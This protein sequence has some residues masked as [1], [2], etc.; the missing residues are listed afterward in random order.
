MAISNINQLLI[1]NID[2]LAAARPL[3]VN[4]ADDGFINAYLTQYPQACMDSYH[5]NYAEYQTVQ[6]LGNTRLESHFSAEYHAK[7]QHDMVIIHFPKSKA[8]LAFTL[9]MLAGAMR[10]DAVIIIVGEN[11][12]GIKSVQKLSADYLAFSHKVDAARHCLMYI[13]RFKAELPTFNIQDF[14]QYY[15]VQVADK[16]LEVVALPGVFSQKSLDVGTQVLLKHLPN[17]IAGQVLDFGCG[18][19]VIAAYIG[20]LAPEAKLTLV[21]VSALALHS[22]QATLK[23][24]QLHGQCIASNSLSDVTGKYDFVFSNPPFHQGVNTHYAA[25]ESFLSNI[26][27][28]LAI[29]ACITIVANSFLKYPPIMERMIGKTDTLTIEKGFAVYQ[30][31]I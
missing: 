29:N 4:I 11:K 27:P 3:L 18:A 17:N 1:R 7:N 9:A 12:A 20:I 16:T 13:G 28:H 2:A 6:R 22:A 8:E 10:E 23:R 31:Q 24:N 15:P 30:C 21:D 26:K 14:Y 19:G 5:S 25:T